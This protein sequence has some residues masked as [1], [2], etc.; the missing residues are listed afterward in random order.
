MIA[1]DG[2]SRRSSVRALNVS[3]QTA[4]V[5]PAT[6]PPAASM[7]LSVTR[8]NCSSLTAITPSSRSKE[9]PASVAIFSKARESLGKQLPPQPGPGRRKSWPMRLS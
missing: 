7:I 4:I 8:S 2:D 6:S 9:Y 3:P 5:H 1:T